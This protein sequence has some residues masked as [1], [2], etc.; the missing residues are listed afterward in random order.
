VVGKHQVRI[1]MVADTNSA[2]D[3]PKRVKQLPAKYN[4]KTTLVYDVPSHG[5]ADADF[6]LTAP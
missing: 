1:T 3:R 5:S 4:A 6:P 2:D